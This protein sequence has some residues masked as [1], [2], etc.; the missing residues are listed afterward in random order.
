MGI[1]EGGKMALLAAA[2]P[3]RF[4]AIDYALHCDRR[5]GMIVVSAK[6]NFYN[7]HYT[8]AHIVGTTG[9]NT[10]DM[11]ESLQMSAAK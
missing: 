3:M 5:P 11:I 8:S 9:G 1:V 7:V 10:N 2:G 6:F 4:G